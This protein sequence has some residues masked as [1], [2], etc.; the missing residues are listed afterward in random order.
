MKQ[1]DRPG[2][3]DVWGSLQKEPRGWRGA[4]DRE[5]HVRTRHRWGGCLYLGLPVPTKTRR[6]EDRRRPWVTGEVLA[7]DLCT[8]S[9]LVGGPP[10]HRRFLSRERPTQGVTY[11]PPSYLTR[12]RPQYPPRRQERPS[13]TSPRPPPPPT[14]HDLL[15]QSSRTR[16]PLRPGRGVHHSGGVLPVSEE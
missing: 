14:F 2:R 5:R 4:V 6:V 11:P 8:Y 15:R 9:P 10:S 16:P 1:W 7:S 3:P 12:P 13:T